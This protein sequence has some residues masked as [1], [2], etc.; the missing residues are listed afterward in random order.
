VYSVAEVEV[1]IIVEGECPVAPLFEEWCFWVEWSTLEGKLYSPSSPS[2]GSSSVLIP[3][4][5]K[6]LWTVEE[7]V[8]GS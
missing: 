3:R 4:D 2:C 5:P 7:G 6:G 1:S 8:A